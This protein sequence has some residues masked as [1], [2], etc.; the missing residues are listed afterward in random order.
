[1]TS[2]DTLIRVFG[3]LVVGLACT[4]AGCS[5]STSGTAQAPVADTGDATTDDGYTIAVVPKGLGHQFWTTVKAGADAAGDETGSTI[6][7]NGPAKETEVAEQIDIIQDM[8]SRGVDAIVMAAC[9]ENALVE[10]IDNAMDNGIPV[11]TIDSGVQ[12]D[13]PVSFI[14]TDNIAGAVAAADAVAELIG[15]EGEV[16]L[17]PFV[18][19]AATSEQRE[20]GF[21]EGVAKHEGLDLV[22]VIHCNSDVAKAMSATEDMISAHPELKAIFAANE[23][24]CIGAMT[25]LATLGK[26]G[27]VKLVAFD[28]SP[29]QLDA[30]ESGSVQALIVQNPFQMG[31]EGVMRAIDAIEGRDVEKR[32]DTGVTVVT[33]DN[34]NDPDVQ[35]LLNPV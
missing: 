23:A 14:A 20:K 6:L 18:P 35:K 28:A 11:V 31:Y 1:M 2:R 7:W 24:A 33:K 4:L 26:E 3:V 19:G 34:M 25:A 10:T 12:S 8:L 27:D 29:E 5:P 17:I 15:G 9:D 22:S 16:G 13:R 32:I 30:L 21:K